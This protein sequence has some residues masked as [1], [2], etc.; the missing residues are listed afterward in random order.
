MKIIRGIITFSFLSVLLGSCF[1][2]PEFP[3]TP[4][5]EFEKIE[6]APSNGGDD[7][8]IIYFHFQDGNGDLGLTS[9]QIDP[10]F[11]PRLLFMETGNG[12]LEEVNLVKKYNNLPLF[13][14]L[15]PG[16]TGKLATL[17]T[18]RR[19]GYEYMEEYNCAFYFNPA[20]DSVL[21]SANSS[22]LIDESYYDI[23]TFRITTSS[24]PGGG[25]EIVY[26]IRD[27]IY[28]QMNPN[29]YN[30]FVRFFRKTSP[31]ATPEEFDWRKEICSTFD[32]RFPELETRNRPLEGTLRYAIR[33]FGLLNTFGNYHLYL[34]I[35]IKDRAGNKSNIITTPDFRLADI[36]RN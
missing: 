20:E 1:D 15:K 11:H 19:P 31:T 27:T 7:S 12:Q 10:P 9:N 16:Q 6:F 5:I 2:Q 36:R 35:Q 4:Y 24:N 17:R 21:I 18:K 14:E 23:D 3:D 32:A 25:G 26:S 29:H 8:L 13:A 28:F 33:S 22:S 30:I 34:E